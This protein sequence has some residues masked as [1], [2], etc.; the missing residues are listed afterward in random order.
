MN[1]STKAA[2]LLVIIVL[3]GFGVYF[4]ARELPNG[5]MPSQNPTLTPS[6][7][8]TNGAT[9]PPVTSVS[10]IPSP[11]TPGVSQ[12]PLPSPIASNGQLQLSLTIGKTIYALG[13]PVNFTLSIMNISNQTISFTHTGLDFDFQITNDTSNLVYQ[14]SNFRAIA[15]FISTQPLAPGESTSQNF[16]WSQDC[17]FNLSVEGD[18]VVAGSYFLVGLS[19]Q[20]YGLQTAPVLITINKP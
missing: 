7:S 4:A 18:P 10:P 12:T 16:S 17:N 13:E 8:S 19:G 11:S 1:K 6:P 14:Y 3:L 15:Q 5:W 9:Q 20:T 2:V